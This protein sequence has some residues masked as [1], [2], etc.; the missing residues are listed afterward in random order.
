MGKRLSD[1]RDTKGKDASLVLATCGERVA[2]ARLVRAS[3]SVSAQVA[4]ARERWP[5]KP[6][7]FVDLTWKPWL[8]L[9]RQP[10]SQG[11]FALPRGDGDRIIRRA[12]ID[13]IGSSDSNLLRWRSG[14]RDCKQ[15]RKLSE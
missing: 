9:D 15:D 8:A 5:R 1:V 2:L 10:S 7:Q 14:Q 11:D 12:S 3:Q 4:R 13:S 6:C